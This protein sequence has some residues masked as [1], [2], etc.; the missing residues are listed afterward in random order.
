M[1]IQAPSPVRYEIVETARRQVLED[2]VGLTEDQ[3]V[4]ILRLPNEALPA[5]LQLAHEVTR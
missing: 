2:G 5:A 4:E 3:L 1:A